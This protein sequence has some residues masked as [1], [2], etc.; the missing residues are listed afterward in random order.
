MKSESI[1]PA[2]FGRARDLMSMVSKASGALHEAV[3]K[4]GAQRRKKK[5]EMEVE[6][7]K[8]IP[9]STQRACLASDTWNY[10]T[11]CHIG[12]A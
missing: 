7:D 5:A 9:I 6:T 4:G 10:G 11:L 1:A 8:E 2:K 3:E 12:G